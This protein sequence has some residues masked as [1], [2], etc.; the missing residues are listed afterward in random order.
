MQCAVT[1]CARP[2]ANHQSTNSIR[3]THT[4]LALLKNSTITQVPDVFV[5]GMP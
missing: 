3:T 5:L 2:T 4:E 1:H